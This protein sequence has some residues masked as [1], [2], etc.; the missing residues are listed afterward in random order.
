MKWHDVETQIINDGQRFSDR[1][2]NLAPQNSKYVGRDNGRLV[3]Y[4]CR[5]RSN[6][7]YII[8]LLT[9]H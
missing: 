2:K 1:V 3:D 4:I 7:H 6:Q 9:R 8:I 5:R